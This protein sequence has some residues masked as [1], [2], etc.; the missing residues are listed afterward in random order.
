MIT[1]DEAY[2]L[3][4]KFASQSWAR[5]ASEEEIYSFAYE[6]LE[7]VNLHDVNRKMVAKFGEPTA[8]PSGATVSSLSYII[9]WE[10]MPALV[11]AMVALES[12]GMREEALFLDAEI[13]RY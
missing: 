2:E 7:D 5:G 12:A 8:Y 3:G 6:L 13:G 11:I 4:E 9:E 10:L 1:I